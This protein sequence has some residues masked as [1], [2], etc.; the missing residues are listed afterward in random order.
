M[1][2]HMPEVAKMLGVEIGEVFEI[3]IDDNKTFQFRF[4][5]NG[6]QCFNRKMWDEDVV[7]MTCLNLLL[8]GKY[9]IKRK[10]GNP[11]KVNP[12]MLLKQTDLLE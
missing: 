11:K 6:L 5:E 3:K 7:A 12:I 4:T 1:T 2:N 9:A 8:V 10:P